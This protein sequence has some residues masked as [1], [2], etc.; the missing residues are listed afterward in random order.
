MKSVGL[1]LKH[2]QLASTS[3]KWQRCSSF[4]IKD[5]PESVVSCLVDSKEDKGLVDSKESHSSESD[6]F[7]SSF[8][9]Y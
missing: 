4:R 6:S 3:N 5:K 1:E 8:E 7:N 9:K 2:A